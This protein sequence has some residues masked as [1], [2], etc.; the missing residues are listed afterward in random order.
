M[1]V[2][3]R[4]E[5][6][7]YGK[8]NSRSRPAK[9]AGPSQDASRCPTSQ[10][11]SSSPPVQTG[12]SVSG[13]PLLPPFS[14]SP[15]RGLAHTSPAVFVVGVE[16]RGLP[17]G[18]ANQGPSSVFHVWGN[19]TFDRSPDDSQPARSPRLGSNRRSGHPSGAFSVTVSGS[20]VTSLAAPS[21]LGTAS[22]YP[23]LLRSQSFQD[24]RDRKKWTDQKLGTRLA[25]PAARCDGLRPGSGAAEWW[26]AG[27]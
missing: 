18:R 20:S 23:S 6:V 2:S 4:C 3:L 19:R 26:S 27:G 9:C 10:D 14:A 24:T 8:R 5:P 22:F 17:E 12:C 7:T 13:G 25:A 1:A 11:P 16:G 21:T 15:K